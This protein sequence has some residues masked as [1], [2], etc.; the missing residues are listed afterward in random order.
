MARSPVLVSAQVPV[1]LGLVKRPSERA[2][3]RLPEADFRPGQTRPPPGGDQRT[4]A[5]AAG[6]DE[7]DAS[8]EL[9][10]HALES[11]QISVG[12]GPRRAAFRSTGP[13]RKG[14]G[15]DADGLGHVERGL[16]GVG[17]DAG[18]GMA[19]REGPLARGR[20]V[21]RRT[22]A[23]R[24]RTCAQPRSRTLRDP[25]APDGAVSARRSHHPAAVRHCC[26]Q[27]RGET[28]LSEEVLRPDRQRPGPRIVGG[29]RADEPRSTRHDRSSSG[30]GRLRRGSRACA[31]DR[32]RSGPEGAWGKGRS[33]RQWLRRDPGSRRPVRQSRPLRY[34]SRREASTGRETGPPLP[35]RLRSVRETS[36]GSSASI[37]VRPL[38]L[39]VPCPLVG[40][41]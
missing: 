41:G 10:Q 8:E 1:I 3:G 15:V 37:S 36:R 12:S 4:N 34:R 39:G 38:L 24:V 35:I 31:G 22:P 40:R 32:G 29:P 23:P 28:G 18:Q 17:G 19:A 16:A 25:S 27:V 6:T 7:A 11:P 33:T 9:V 26:R 30:H 2:K 13:A 20:S 5:A 14:V 21:R